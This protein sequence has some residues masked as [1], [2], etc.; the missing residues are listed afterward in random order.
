MN[1]VR[2]RS[3]GFTLVEL[4]VVIGIIAVLISIL[5]PTLGRARNSANSLAC[6]SNLRSIGQMITMYAGN[7]KQSLPYG[8]WDGVGSP[9]G[10]EANSSTFNA[11]F[12]GSTPNSSDWQLLLMSNVLKKGGPTVSE[13]APDI[14]SAQGV[15]MCPSAS[16]ENRSG[17]P[18]FT[19]ERRLHYSSHPRLMPR[20]DD[21]Q[22]SGVDNTRLRPYKIGGIRRSSEIIMIFDASQITN[23]GD[24]NAYP[25]ATGLD[26]NGLYRGDTQSGRKWNYLIAEPTTDLSPAVF[27][28]NRDWPDA[29]GQGRT[30]IRWR[31][32]RNDLANFLYADGHADS[33]RLKKNV[34]S[35][36]KLRNVFVNLQK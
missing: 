20:L 30:D 25:V 34:N 5:L 9:D 15:F 26:S 27:T 11:F 10:I 3:S 22:K 24:G 2:S 12:A 18:T 16:L 14:A 29:A 6:M 7:N 28:A 19:T 17:N 35:D 1:Y 13:I 36:I 4:L 32:G 21:P 8:Y 23:P 31:H 33:I